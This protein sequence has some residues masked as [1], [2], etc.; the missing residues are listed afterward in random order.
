MIEHI[1]FVFHTFN[2]RTSIEN[3]KII[4]SKAFSSLSFSMLSKE[5]MPSMKLRRKSEL[6]SGSGLTTSEVLHKS[7]HFGAKV[8]FEKDSLKKV[9]KM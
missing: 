2:N 3:K 8:Q 1:P 9:E 5:L 6:R 4:M 7:E